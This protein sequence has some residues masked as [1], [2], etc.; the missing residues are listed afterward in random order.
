MNDIGTTHVSHRISYFGALRNSH[1]Q[2]IVKKRLGTHAASNGWKS[3]LTE[4]VDE[5]LSARIKM[6]AIISPIAICKPLPPLVFRLAIIAPMIERRNTETGVA[7]RRYLST[8]NV[9]RPSVPRC[10]SI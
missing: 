1:Q 7:L 10:S 8:F 5:N 3:P 6:A 9:L 4:K 2:M